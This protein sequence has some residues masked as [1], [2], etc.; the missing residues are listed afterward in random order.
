MKIKGNYIHTTVGEFSWWITSTT[1]K[2]VIL[3]FIPPLLV[4][5][6][7]FRLVTDEALKTK[8][9]YGFAVLYLILYIYLLW[10]YVSWVTNGWTKHEVKRWLN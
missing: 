2:G 6:L 8:L 4:A 3:P 9:Y 10:K 5:E 7:L 1:F